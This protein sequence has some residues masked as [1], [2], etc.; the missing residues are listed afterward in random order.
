MFFKK[1]L[2]RATDWSHSHA[3]YAVTPVDAG[4]SVAAP[5]PV[6]MPAPGAMPVVTVVRPI[7]VAVVRLMVRHPRTETETGAS[8]CRRVRLSRMP[9]VRRAVQRPSAR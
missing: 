7:V 9:T 6:V 1:T 3:H 2:G 4:L 5:V 8:H